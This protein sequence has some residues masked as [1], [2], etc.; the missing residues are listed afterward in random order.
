[1]NLQ[2]D[3]NNL[4]KSGGTDGQKLVLGSVDRSVG[5]LYGPFSPPPAM[6]VKEKHCSLSGGMHDILRNRLSRQRRGS[7]LISHR[8]PL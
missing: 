5:S 3:R 8:L 2:F 6:Q 1:M 4:N 7:R